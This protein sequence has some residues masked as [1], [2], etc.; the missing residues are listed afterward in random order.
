MSDPAG[1]AR[2]NDLSLAD[3]TIDSV[4]LTR[5][6]AIVTCHDWQEKPMRL[7]FDDPL[8]C[9]WM[10]PEDEDLSHLDVKETGDLLSATEAIRQD[11]SSEYREFVFVS[12]WTGNAILRIVARS[13]AVERDT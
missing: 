2:Q 8:A 9:E 1:S 12:A 10:S 11:D 4:S 3:A 5:G 13:M 6:A 7:R